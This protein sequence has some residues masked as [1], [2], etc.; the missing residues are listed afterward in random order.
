MAHVEQLEQMAEVLDSHPDYKILR[1]MPSDRVEIVAARG[2]N[3]LRVAILDVETTGLQFGQD[4]IIE[5]GVILV[6]VDPETYNSLGVID[7]F[8][9]F[10][11]PG[12]P[13]P[14]ETT[15]INGITDT[16]VAGQRLDEKR[17][18]AMFSGVDL[19]VAHNAGFDRKFVEQRLPFFETMNWACSQTQI[20]WKSEGIASAKLE[21]LANQFGFFY[22][23]HRAQTDC[24]AL[25]KVLTAPTGDG[26]GL[27]QLITQAREPM[28]RIWATNSHFDSKDALKARGYAWDPQRRCWSIMAKK[29]DIRDEAAWLRDHVFGGRDVVLEFEA[30][31]AK[32]RFSTRRGEVAFKR[33][34]A[35]KKAA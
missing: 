26:T 15:A 24:L 1:R 31:D 18:A 21:Y 13:I 25:M 16:Q 32:V 7:A 23:A 12:F 14:A 33:V 8:Q 3:N 2:G 22:D 6:E 11:D 27:A 10:E 35:M 4:K 19:V 5:L 9:G 28:M 34:P 20:N 29:P 17:L 30:L